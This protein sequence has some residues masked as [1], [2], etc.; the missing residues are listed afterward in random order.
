MNMVV[1]RRD[2]QFNVG[3]KTVLHASLYQS[4]I[5]YRG[6]SLSLWAEKSVHQSERGSKC[7]C[8]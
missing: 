2:L 4:F 8:E 1:G 5:F 7:L 6:E 3:S